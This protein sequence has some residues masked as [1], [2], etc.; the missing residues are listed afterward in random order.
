MEEKVNKLADDFAKLH[1]STES[2][3]SAFSKILL[4]VKNA[5]QKLD[6]SD[7]DS[8][9]SM[10]DTHKNKID[11]R[12]IKLDDFTGLG[13]PEDFLEWARQLEKISDY[14]G[15]DDSKRFKIA[16]IR[17]TKNAGLWFENLKARRA[18]AGKDK[19][20]TWTALKKKMRSKY[21]PHDF[22]QVQYLKLTLLTQDTKSVNEYIA[23]FDRLTSLCDLEEKES[24]R[25]A[26]FIKGLNRPIAKKID[27]STYETFDDVC[28]L[29]L[30]IENHWLEDKKSSKFGAKSSSIGEAK[31]FEK[32]FK[33]YSTA[34]SEQKGESSSKGE[35]KNVKISK[36]ELES[37]MRCFRC[38]GRGHRAD[39][40]PSKRT[41]TIKQYR[42]MEEEEER[43]NFEEAK[44]ESDLDLSNEEDGDAYAESE[45]SVLVVRK[46][47]HTEATPVKSQR[48]NLFHTR[49]KVGDKTCRMIIDSG[50]CT[51]VASTE[52]VSK[53]KLP[54]RDH[55]KP[56]KLSWL[57]DS[58]GLLVKKQGLVNFSIGK[59]K[60]ELWCDVIPMSACH[61]LLGRPWQFD[62]QVTHD[63][64]TNIYSVKMGNKRIKL[65]P[66][67][68]IPHGP[69]E[70]EKK[71]LVPNLFLNGKEFEKEVEDGATVFALVVKEVTSTSS[72]MDKHLGDLLEEFKDV[73]PKE[74]PKG[75]PPMRGIEHAIDLIPGASLPN[76]PAYRCD[77]TAVKARIEKMND[78]YKARSNKKRK[79]PTFKPGDLVWLHL[80]KERF[81]QKR[82]N[83]LMPRADGPFEVLEAY[84][85]SAYKLD[86]PNEYGNVSATF[87]V[88]DLSPYL[89]DVNL[90]A[91]SFE[92]GENDVNQEAN[93]FE[94][95]EEPITLVLSPIGFG[96]E[97]KNAEFK[98]CI[99]WELAR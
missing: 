80:R 1:D 25:I 85:D 69:K 46:V 73:F 76:K 77:P 94:D 17:L 58:K 83:K 68:P 56:Y 5:V 15:F 14:K 71:E 66:L 27:L 26:R 99:A 55:V 2:R 57:D 75:L 23:E 84:G 37:R 62:R 44:G 8:S 21:L 47:L 41:L 36:E 30:K 92:E 6:Q 88:G 54:T 13:S 33:T 82:K 48:E 53:L 65:H 45:D 9:F 43:I 63:G 24:M 89:D 49:C 12:G 52:M 87:N 11:D 51:N 7:S 97:D 70:K 42:Q 95:L 86:L 34:S 91:N 61:I 28:T 20:K 90:R 96:I 16:Y 79:Q 10:D 32:P 29:A 60:E 31:K 18:R 39:Q 35:K 98:T 78:Q 93:S 74:L 59:Y 72:S 3:F 81:P 40:C 19:I 50:S 64:E 22:E 67:S 4:E 38:Q